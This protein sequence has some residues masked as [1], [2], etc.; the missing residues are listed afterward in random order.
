MIDGL[1]DYQKKAILDTYQWLGQNKGNPCIV[2]PTGSGKSWIIAGLCQDIMSRWRKSRIIVLSHVKE[3]LSQD[4]EKIWLAWPEAPLG[5]YSAGL[6]RKDI[7]V[8]TVAGIQSIYRKAEEAGKTDLVIVDEAHRIN[9]ESCGMY[10][11]F[12]N[13]LREINPNL[14]IIGLTAT[15]YR[16]GQGMVTEGKEAL[17]DDLI[18]SISIR[19]LVSQGY[20]APLRNKRTETALDT[21]GVRVQNGDFVEADMEARFNNEEMNRNIVAEVMRRGENRNAILVFCCGISHAKAIRDVFREDMMT[22][23]TLTGK[24]PPEE[25]E[26][27]LKAFKA[28]EIRVLTNVNVLTTGF[29]YPNIDLIVMARPT[30]SPGLYMQMAGRGMRLKDGPNKDCLVLDFAG[31]IRRHGPVTEITPPKPGRG[32]DKKDGKK[33]DGTPPTKDCPK[34]GEICATN[35]RTCPGCGYEFP[36]TLTE[37]NEEDDIMGNA[38]QTMKLRGW[39]WSVTKSRNA[40]IP[41]LVL[42]LYPEALAENPIRIY[43]CVNHGGY[44]QMKARKTLSLLM[45]EDCSCLNFAYIEEWARKFSEHLAPEWVNYVYHKPFYE[46]KD[47]G[48]AEQ[49][50]AACE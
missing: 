44:A 45:G 50:K 12:L 3:L 30:L 26:R 14:R 27:I 21:R 40:G 18:E 20:L 25:R 1:R 16:L 23:E 13:G 10:R 2:A 5:I 37:V 19:D 24:T 35:A 22:A 33:E 4:A 28:G 34:C 42:D 31:N 41:M 43:L 48:R 47:C 7:D 15:P 9:N 46:I 6:G 17:F 38:V 32:K 39:R 49:E 36:L 11:T 8:I 29:D